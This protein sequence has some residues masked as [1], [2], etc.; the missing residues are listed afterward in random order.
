MDDKFSLGFNEAKKESAAWTSEVF[1]V[2]V[3]GSFFLAGPPDV[4]YDA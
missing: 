4:P 3:G 1:G 2:E